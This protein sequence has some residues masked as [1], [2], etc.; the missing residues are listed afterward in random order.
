[1][2]QISHLVKQQE[3]SEGR[4]QQE[5]KAKQLTKAKHQHK[6]FE[7]VTFQSISLGWFFFPPKLS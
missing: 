3:S 7:H 1:M 2:C 5:T 4:N 6:L